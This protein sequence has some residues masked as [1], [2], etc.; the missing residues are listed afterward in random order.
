MVRELRFAHWEAQEQLPRMRRRRAHVSQSAPGQQHNR[1]WDAI[2]HPQAPEA[3]D[4]AAGLLHQKLQMLNC[5]GFL[6]R[7]PEAGFVIAPAVARQQSAAVTDRANAGSSGISGLAQEVRRLV[8]ER[9]A[10]GPGEE[11]R[12]GGSAAASDTDYASCCDDLA[13]A[14]D[15]DAVADSFAEPMEVDA[16]VQFPSFELRLPSPVT[17]DMVAE[18]EAARAALG[19]CSLIHFLE[20][21]L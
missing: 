8:G 3:P 7:H 21:T 15:L 2:K 9:R 1:H 10:P 12:D 19:V 6:R 5:C 4:L 18:Q 11:A 14:A 17:S 13:A 20:T 16:D